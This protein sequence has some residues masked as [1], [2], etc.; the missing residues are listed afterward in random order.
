M[1]TNDIKNLRQKLKELK[2]ATIVCSR[3]P[4]LGNEGKL[5]TI[6]SDDIDVYPPL[7]SQRRTWEPPKLLF[8]MNLSEVKCQM[9]YIVRINKWNWRTGVRELQILYQT[10]EKNWVGKYKQGMHN[11]IFLKMQNICPMIL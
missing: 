2:V 3:F 11:R 7:S 9:S 4:L 6:I 1:L 10:Y 8:E 5:L